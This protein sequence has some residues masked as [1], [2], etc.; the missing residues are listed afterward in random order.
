ML[1][2]IIQSMATP[3]EPQTD[4]R[5]QRSERSREAIVQA[6]LDLIGEE[7]L[8]PTAEQVAVRAEVG[9]RTVFR[10][11]SDM[12][13]L[14]ATISERLLHQIE[15]LVVHE[16]QQGPFE[17]R[18]E[19][20]IDRRLSLFGKLSPY[21]RSSALQRSRSAFLQAQHARDVRALR[22]D[23]Q[24][25]LPELDREEPELLDLLEVLLSFEAYNRLRTEQKLGLRRTEAAI[26]RGAYELTRSRKG[27]TP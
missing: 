6:L 19:S 13:T 23:L 17:A 12:E 8:T 5:I 27:K 15:A 7:N 21:M 4:G 16:V 14:F 24:R 26:R 20:V 18:L 9:V 25:S 11:F 3:S 10:H 2:A 22:R 1:Y